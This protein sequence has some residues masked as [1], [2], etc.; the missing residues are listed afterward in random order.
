MIGTS[1]FLYPAFEIQGFPDSLSITSE[2][3]LVLKLTNKQIKMKSINFTAIAQLGERQT[4]DLEIPSSI[5]GGGIL[6]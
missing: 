2:T 6:H 5:L 3:T 4:V 1:A